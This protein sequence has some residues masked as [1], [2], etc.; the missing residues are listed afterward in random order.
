MRSLR[1]AARSSQSD[2]TPAE[3]PLDLL[4]EGSYYSV[5]PERS[6][7]ADLI[8]AGR[9]FPPPLALLV[10]RDV[11]TRQ[12]YAEYLRLS[13]Y[14][15]EE[16]EDGRDALAKCIS[17]LPDIL[18]TETRLPGMDGFQLCNLLRNDATTK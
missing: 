7:Q 2:P 8:P 14:T 12:M 16:A 9:P 18:I 5:D 4:C 15:I 10:D 1:P 13:A 6:M 11:D 17:L 3:Y